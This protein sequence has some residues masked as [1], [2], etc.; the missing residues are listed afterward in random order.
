[1]PNTEQS[2][3]QTGGVPVIEV[4]VDVFGMAMYPT[5]KTL[6][7]EDMPADAKATGDAI[8]EANSDIAEM[9]L[10]IKDLQERT[11]ADIPLNRDAGAPTIAAAIANT[12][13]N[14]YPVGSVYISAADSLPSEIAA[15]GTWVEIA[16]PIRLVDIKKGSRTYA[17]A[18]QDYEHGNLRMWLRTA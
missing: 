1:M 10:D 16:M 14:T 15:I 7:V 12:F 6:S 11:G 5:D 9:L 17:E 8:A 3:E 4:E 2:I 18:G 13:G